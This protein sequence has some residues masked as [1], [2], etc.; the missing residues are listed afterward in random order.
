MRKRLSLA[1]ATAVT[2]VSVLSGTVNAASEPARTATATASR[3][4]DGSKDVIANLWEWNW[5]SVAE[6][7]TTVLGPKGYGGVQVAPPQNSVSLDHVEGKPKQQSWEVYQPVDYTLESR[8]GTEKQFKAM[9][10]TCRAAGVKVYVDVVVNHM[11]RDGHESYGGASYTHYDYPGLY[12]PADFH[13]YPDDCPVQPPADSADENTIRNYND[14]RQVTQ[15]ELLRLADLR[16][17]TP[18]VRKQ[19]AAY[20]NKLIRYG[21]SGFR[22]DAAKHVG[23]SDLAAIIGRLDR[24]VDGEKPYVALEVFPGPG[25][26]SPF[27]FQ[28]QGSLLG[29]D[30]AYQIKDTFKSYDGGDGNITAL[31]TLGERS[32]LLPGDKSLV[33]VQNHDSE[34]GDTTLSYRDADTNL[35]ANKFMLA[36]GYGRPQVYASYAFDGLATDSPPS[37]AKGFVTDT[38]CDA[39]WACVDRDTGVANMVAWHNHVGDAKLRNWY[40]DGANLLAF[41]RGDK[42]WIAVNNHRT[43]RTATFRT[44]LPGGT[45]CDV[46]HGALTHGKCT[47]PTVEVNRHGEARVTV[48]AKDTVAFTDEDL[49]RR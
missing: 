12:G 35:L 5:P 22:V 27:A 47:G 20:L 49:V 2:A 1:V 38:D 39:G 36:Y 31:R 43:A 21:V 41:S 16:T 8:M 7:C 46:T 34:R 18:R 32:G 15:C 4:S 44:G 28:D 24:T 29:I 23:Q 37:D 3:P 33:F 13:T 6:E 10:A 45:Y 40:D 48:A 42:G 25:A 9:V 14:Y 11:A 17:E 30:Y 26:L 19:I